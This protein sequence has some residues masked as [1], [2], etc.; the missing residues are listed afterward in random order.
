MNK[1]C[2]ICLEEGIVSSIF[3]KNFGLSLAEM[4]EFSCD[5][6]IFRGD[7]LPEQLCSNCI[8]KLGVAYHFKR[9]CVS[10]EERLRQYLGITFNSRNKDV[11]VMTDP[12]PAPT[13]V[14]TI[15]KCIC[16]QKVHEKRSNYKKKPESEKLKRGPKPKPKTIHACYQCDKEFK[17]Q[18]QLELHI[19]TH[20]GDKPFEC[21][22]CHKKFAQKHNL[23]IHQRMHTGEKPFQCEICS[24]TFSAQ[25]NLQT[26]V[27]IHTGQKDHICTICSKS[28]ITSS[29][30]TRHMSKHR[31]DKNFK[32]DICDSAFVQ[33]R[34]LKLHKEKK[35]NIPYVRKK[36]QINDKHEEID[37]EE[38]SKGPPAIFKE[39]TI[40][41]F[42]IASHIQPPVHT[43]EKD[44]KQMMN[45]EGL[46]PNVTCSQCG[47]DF[48][49]LSL[50]VQ[51]YLHCSK[52]YQAL[53]T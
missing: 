44:I 13:V 43:N 36:V 42:S 19:R 39:H 53:H 14:T 24:K 27:K 50:L 11:E 30:L 41:N 7:G 20:T 12:T 16:K 26:H 2:R 29:D 15:R 17:C 23:T 3:S 5:I 47:E 33:S 40:D 8:Y 48:E 18:A 38:V 28:F 37:I 35:H 52:G 46:Q 31:G 32:C 25:G 10:A 22:H 51:H 34:D 49:Y 9:T 1:I 6:K 21:M 45:G 4:I